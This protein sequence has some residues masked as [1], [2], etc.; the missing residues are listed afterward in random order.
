[1]KRRNFACGFL[2]CKASY[3]LAELLADLLPLLSTTSSNHGSGV[4]MFADKQFDEAY[5]TTLIENDL[6][7]VRWGRV[8]YM[9]VTYLTTKWAV[10]KWGAC[11]F[12]RSVH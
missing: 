7:H 5:N 2:S 8:D 4:S 10:W 6:P 9:S 3:I 1:M 12:P 11:S